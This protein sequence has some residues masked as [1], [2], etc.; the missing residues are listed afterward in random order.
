[1]SY[2]VPQE[3]QY[4][5]IIIFGLTWKQLLYASLSVIPVLFILKTGF[6]SVINY[7]VVLPIIVV[8]FGFVFLDF[9]KKIKALVEFKKFSNVTSNSEKMKNFLNV[10]DIKE[11][12][13]ILRDES[14]NQSSKLSIVRVEPVNILMKSND[15]RDAICYGFQKFLNSF[16]FPIQFLVTSVEKEK[17]FYKRFHII[18]PEKYDLKI[19]TS[20]VIKEI[21]SLG[22]QAK[23]LN[24]YE[25]VSLYNNYFPNKKNDVDF[26]E[27]KKDFVHYLVSPSRI[28]NNK[29][30]LYFDGVFS[31]IINVIGYPRT[32]SFGFL[33]KIIKV[34][35]DV[36]VS[37]HVEP[38]SIEKL[39]IKL[40]RE[41]QKQRADL[42]SIN[43]KGSTNPVLEI[44]HNDT[45][46]V[47]E[48]LQKG[49]EKLFLISFYVMCKAVSKEE[50]DKLSQTVVT[51]LNSVLM[52]PEV[53]FYLQAQALKSCLPLC[54]NLLENKRNITTK[55]LSAFFPFTSK[56]YNQDINGI[57]FGIN[58]NKSPVIKNIF[59]LPNHNGVILSMSGGGKS[60]LTKLLV[61][62]YNSQGVKIFVIDP[63]GE[64][65]ALTKALEGQVINIGLNE[66][67][68]INP[69]D[70]MGYD[71]KNKKLSLME[72]FILMFPDMTDL[73]KSI[74]DQAVNHVYSN[75][76]SP[77][78]K[79]LYDY[80]E[81]KKKKIGDSYE[82][83]VYSVLLYKLS[84]Y[85]TG[86]FSFLN[87][88]TNIEVKKNLICFHLNNLPS[89]LEPVLTYLIMDFL[90]NQMKN[91]ESKKLLFIDEAWTVLTKTNENSLLFR[92][93]KTCRKYKMGVFLITQEAEDLLSNK[94][95]R[96]LL[97]NSSTN[98]LLRQ[99]PNV[100]KQLRDIFNLN[101]EECYI[102]LN[103]SVGNGIMIFNDEREQV[104]ITSTEKEQ[105]LN[106]LI[107]VNKKEE[108][109]IPDK[110]YDKFYYQYNDLSNEEILYLTDSLGYVVCNCIPIS[111]GK[112]QKFLVKKTSRESPQH[113]FYVHHIANFLR[114]FTDKIWTYESVNPDIVFE[115][116]NNKYALEIETGICLKSHQNRVIEKA[117]RLNKEY[118]DNWYF[119]ILDK[120]YTYFYQKYG[121]VLNRSILL[122]KIK[123]IEGGQSP[124]INGGSLCFETQENMNKSK[125]L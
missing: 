92:I 21:K 85:T 83:N 4:K 30:F 114:Q 86:S 36:T 123:E 41:L 74:L 35:N 97:T 72:L 39:T 107:T 99:K 76:P 61:Q 22:L 51:E 16:D 87:N 10:H 70:L 19:Q 2:E 28:E 56:F 46:R 79:D 26:K 8:G 77:V 94:T 14:F 45:R 90:Y 23:K 18:I 47:L 65:T 109:I 5:E 81:E 101:Q 25:I 124:S 102:L 62:R 95:G 116:N 53:S 71:L 113:T 73:Q 75:I 13:I 121:K 120:R 63:E 15:E 69:L 50:L 3:I 37:I 117:K 84:L 104:Q 40:N 66:S 24:S 29:D 44:K 115:I 100:I 52:I 103:S 118:K 55:P 93:I 96:S 9:D 38:F 111:K 125:N 89:I 6:T 12:T 54:Q 105:E 80:L 88:Q 43:Q 91:I 17:I 106:D 20:L 34:P 11:D 27:L 1:M 59:L 58:E 112:S 78:L 57:L 119:V 108:N 98:I 110:R 64:Y 48:E 31:R 33:D 49:E 82:M 32:V 42:Y 7:V 67:N 68:V 122:K 60:Y